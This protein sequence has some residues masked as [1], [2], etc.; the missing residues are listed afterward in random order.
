MFVV[1]PV[2]VDAVMLI[3]NS[4][5]LL[6]ILLIITVI[7]IITT[8]IMLLIMGIEVMT[9]IILKFIQRVFHKTKIVI[10][11]KKFLILKTNIKVF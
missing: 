3:N 9:I 11:K 4:S 6:I 10:C 7:I 2:V 5:M 8:I 1:P